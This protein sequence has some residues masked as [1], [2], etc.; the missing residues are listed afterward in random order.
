MFWLNLMFF[1]IKPA[2]Y[3]K[4]PAKNIGMKSV[5]TESW[6]AKMPHKIA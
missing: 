2:S 6:W 4:R 5:Q 3:G 1:K